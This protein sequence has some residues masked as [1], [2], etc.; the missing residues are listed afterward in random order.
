MNISEHPCFNKELAETHE[1]IHLPVA[2]KCN[3]LCNFCN[4][5]FDCL[6]ESRPG[7]TTKVISPRQALAYLQEADKLA[8]KL[9][10]VGIAGPGDPFASPNETMETLR[11]VRERYPKKLLCVATNGLELGP[12]IE[13]LAELNVSHVTVTMNAVDP[14]VAAEVY[15]WGRFKKK[16]YRG[17]ELGELIVE[18]QL[19]NLKKIRAY[20]MIAKVNSII[21]PG[22]N[23][24]HIPEVAK[25][26]AE[27]GAQVMNCI[28]M[29]PVEGTAFEP[30]G[31]PDD[32]TVSRVR[33]QSGMH[34]RQMAHCQRCRADAA[35]KLHEG[36]KSE[37]VELLAK[38]SSGGLDNNRP[39]VAVASREG[40]LVNQHLGEAVRFF[41]YEAKPG[42]DSPYRLVDL[43]PAPAPGQGG[44]RWEQLAESLADCRSVLVHAAGATPKNAL[45]SS[46]I[47]VLEME[48][49]IE[50][51]L[52]AVFEDRELPKKLQR[53][54]QGCGTGCQGSGTGC[55]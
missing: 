15:A 55:G 33:F 31:E 49:L 12:Y 47:Q 48:G 17:P 10:V 18:E 45:Q 19:E 30:L 16:I 1:R 24:E 44:R 27:A 36:I 51:G 21:I 6:N 38:A 8:E 13:E 39:Y 50:E 53:S 54:F 9:S 25:V 22:I 23:D 35:G 52:R 42:K 43:R 28:P 37:Y 3:V 5:K 2:P 26:A 20:G 29:V 46:G 14:S 11:L 32:K 41:I 7:V 40:A 4:R 34:V